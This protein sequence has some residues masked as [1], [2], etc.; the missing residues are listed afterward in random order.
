MRPEQ[1]YIVDELKERYAKNSLMI[2]ASYHGLNAKNMNDLRTSVFEIEGRIDIVKNRLL[3]RIMPE[4]VEI[5]PLNSLLKGPSTIAATDNDIIA[6]AKALS[7]FAKANEQLEIRGGILELSKI[8]NADDI[9]ALASLP[10]R[11]IL[12]SRLLG[13]IK[14]PVTNFTRLLDTMVT[15]VVRVIDQVA[16]AKEEAGETVAETAP[17]EEVKPE[18]EEK[19]EAAPA[20]EAKPEVEEKAETA[21]TEEAK[22]EVEEKAETAPIEEAKPEAEEKAEAA[23]AEEAKPEAEEKAEAAPAE[24][25]KPEDEEKE[26][27]AHADEAKQE[28]E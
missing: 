15:N 17:A 20:E 16:K 28:A 8:L 21:P 7:E 23:P 3:K 14:G 4:D 24:E 9:I 25:D 5:E 18:V 12:L 6:L 19:A 2:V 1:K 27:A 11:E 22:P 13:A 10:P 26:E